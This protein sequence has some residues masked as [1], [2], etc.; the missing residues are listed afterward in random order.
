MALTN[1]ADQGDYQVRTWFVLFAPNPPSCRPDKEGPALSYF[2]LIEDRRVL[3][4]GTLS[5]SADWGL[6]ASR[7]SH[8]QWNHRKGN[9]RSFQSLSH[10]CIESPGLLVC[11][12]E[13]FSSWIP[14]SVC[15]SLARYLIRDSR[16]TLLSSIWPTSIISNSL[17]VLPLSDTFWNICQD[18]CC[19]TSSDSASFSH[20]CQDNQEF[21]APSKVLSFAKN[22]QSLD[23][24]DR[25]VHWISFFH[26]FFSTL[27][28]KRK[29]YF[30]SKSDA[31]AVDLLISVKSCLCRL[32]V[33]FN[34]ECW[35]SSAKQ[36]TNWR[37]AIV[38]IARDDQLIKAMNRQLILESALM[39]GEESYCP[40]PW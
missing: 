24:H 3:L 27:T 30:H 6:K 16:C 39:I 29:I 18:F 38:Q 23:L 10:V 1:G 14:T 40:V 36:R 17:I 35:R 13:L 21:V 8:H 19:S 2:P 4:I 11:F 34:L 32:C 31:Q 26:Q 33:V 20:G 7:R 22:F 5:Y 28:R 12:F 37:L 15:Q 25:S 9:F